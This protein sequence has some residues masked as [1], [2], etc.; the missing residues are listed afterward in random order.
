MALACWWDGS[1]EP[2]PAPW[3]DTRLLWGQLEARRGGRGC[4]GVTTC[5]ATVWGSV[6]PGGLTPTRDTG[7]RQAAPAPCR[8]WLPCRSKCGKWG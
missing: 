1:H 7:L 5:P 8:L 4:C 6:L 3:E 2:A